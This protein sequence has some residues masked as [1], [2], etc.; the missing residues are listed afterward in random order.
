MSI[1]E[2]IFLVFFWTWALTSLLFLR[3]TLLIPRPVAA[4]ISA[5]IPFTTVHFPATDGISLE[6]WMVQTDPKKPW[7]ILCHGLGSN[8]SDLIE[9]ANGLYNAGFNLFLFDFRGHGRSKTHITTFG[10]KE[11]HDLEGALAFLSQHPEVPA[12]PYGIY[13]ISMGASVA[14]MVGGRDER[15]GAI[16]VEGPFPNLQEAFKHYMKLTYPWLPKIPFLWFFLATYRICF[17]VWPKKVSP[18]ASVKQFDERPLFII[19]G[20]K[21][22]R[23]PLVGTKRLFEQASCPKELWVIENADHLEGFG[24]DRNTYLHRLMHFFS[25]YLQ[26]SN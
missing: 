1:V 9:V 4:V 23:T 16:A 21:D 18:E 20:A 12:V 10:W 2:V 7:I 6:G 8:H 25:F 26:I 14:L 24:L 3:T 11:Q 17:G 22:L 13:G 19:Q 5:T 15:L